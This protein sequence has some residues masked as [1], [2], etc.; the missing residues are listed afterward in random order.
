MG[1]GRDGCRRRERAAG[2]ARPRES[3]LSPACACPAAA[4][5]R[6]HPRP[7]SEEGT[8]AG[9]RH[10]A[11]P[12]AQ[13][14]RKSAVKLPMC[15]PRSTRKTGSSGPMKRSR[16]TRSSA[17]AGLRMMRDARYAGIGPP[18]APRRYSSSRKR[19]CCTLPN[20][21]RRKRV[22]T[23]SYKTRF[24]SCG[25]RRPSNRCRP[26]V[27]RKSLGDFRQRPDMS[28]L[29]GFRGLSCRPC[30]WS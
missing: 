17:S 7:E 23:V 15:A 26:V 9:S 4:P 21:R 22:S 19:R 27:P 10:T 12:S 11:A 24:V 3:L 18:R 14:A 13:Q 2:A 20:C 30:V 28:G 1:A 5:R 16:C 25:L 6:H 29:S 8:R